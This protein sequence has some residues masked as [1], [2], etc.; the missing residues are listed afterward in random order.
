MIECETCGGEGYV[1]EMVCYGGSP[2]EKKDVCPD[3]D[4]E[5]ERYTCEECKENFCGEECHVTGL[6]I[7]N[8]QIACDDFRE[9]WRI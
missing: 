7:Y 3:C 1:M 5:G 2:Y 4:G 9:E 6:E 8:D